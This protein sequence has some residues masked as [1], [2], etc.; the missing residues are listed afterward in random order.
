MKTWLTHIFCVLSACVSSP[1]QSCPLR[2]SPS[3]PPSRP[4][5]CFTFLCAG[6]ESR[7]A[8]CR[9]WQRYAKLVSTLLARRDSAARCVVALSVRLLWSF[10]CLSAHS[11]EPRTGR[12][13]GQR[14]PGA[15]LF[16]VSVSVAFPFSVRGTVGGR[17]PWLPW[18]VLLKRFV[19][20][21]RGSTQQLA[22]HS[23]RAPLYSLRTDST[24][25]PLSTTCWRRSGPAV[26]A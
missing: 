24:A 16:R 2:R 5:W 18:E 25:A 7:D 6:P 17:S 13:V 26:A 11:R 9:G 8:P 10:F 1:H 3:W 22:S 4:S 15:A 14:A 21:A 20:L 19:N 12:G 23:P